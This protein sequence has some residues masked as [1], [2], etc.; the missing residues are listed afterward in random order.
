MSKFRIYIINLDTD[1]DRWMN[2]ENQLSQLE[3]DFVRIS[4]V[5]LNINPELVKNKYSFQRNQKEFYSDLTV[6]EIGCY[7][8]H[9]ECWKKI[10][11]EKL[12]YAFI[13]E[14]DIIIRSNFRDVVYWFQENFDIL[15]PWDCIKLGEFPEKRRVVGIERIRNFIIGNYLKV[16][17]GTF[18]QA[19]S[20]DGAKKLLQFSNPFYAPVDIAIQLTWKNNLRVL[21]LKPYP[22]GAYQNSS[23]IDLL[24]SRERI[25]KRRIVKLKL[26]F[27]FFL[28]KVKVLL[29]NII[30]HNERN[31]VSES[32]T[33]NSS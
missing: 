31:Y 24:E 11:A 27:L 28:Q 29:R 33:G 4:G 1:K 22:V 2:I 15:E 26:N 25:R 5:N 14:D 13:L 7:L 6:G 17:S 10:L 9:I 16:P 12:D 23:S 32:K 20:S 21:A 8:S 30:L 18:A 3:L 19:I